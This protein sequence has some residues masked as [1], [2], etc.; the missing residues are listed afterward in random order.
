MGLSENCDDDDY[1]KYIIDIFIFNPMFEKNRRD[2]EN[3]RDSVVMK[4]KTRTSS[5]RSDNTSS[6]ND[7]NKVE[8]YS[9]SYRGTKL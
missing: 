2:L 7:P 4:H 1:I 5:E 9:H 8:I 3:P 6:G